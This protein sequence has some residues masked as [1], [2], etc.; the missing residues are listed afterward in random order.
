MTNTYLSLRSQVWS[1]KQF[2]SRYHSN[3]LINASRH[4]L[5]QVTLHTQ[6]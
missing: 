5:V 4:E 2:V 3:L 6:L 1:E